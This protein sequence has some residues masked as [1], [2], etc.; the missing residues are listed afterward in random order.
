MNEPRNRSTSGAG[1][2]P[3]CGVSRRDVGPFVAGELPEPDRRRLESHLRGCA[4]CTAEAALLRRLLQAVAAGEPQEPGPVYWEAF[5]PRLRRRLEADRRRRT[6]ATRWG[7]AAAVLLAAGLAAEGGRSWWGRR[8]APGPVARE[9]AARATLEEIARAEARLDDLLRAAVRA[10]T[11][12]TLRAVEDEV[13]AD[14]PLA[15]EDD[16]IRL[17]APER[18][19]LLR[20]MTSDE[21]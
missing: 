14:D 11:G 19:G 7:I 21:G 4:G 3:G 17:S 18:A 20:R 16:L 13:A 8:P 5:G 10:R 12:G 9:V 2:G 6:R 1:A 15:L